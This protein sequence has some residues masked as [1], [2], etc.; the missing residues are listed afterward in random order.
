MDLVVAT[1]NIH[2]AVGR[3]GRRDADRIITVLREVDADVIALQEADERFGER[4][5][6]LPKAWIDDTPW[7]IVPLAKRPRSMGWHGNALLVR[8]DI[9][10]EAAMP[11]D[12]PTLEPRGA[13]LAVLERDGQRFAIVG[14]HLCLSGMRRRA[15]IKAILAQIDALPGGDALA[16]LITGDF[17]Q[18]GVATGAMRAFDQ[19]ASGNWQMIAPDATFPSNRAIARLDRIVASKAWAIS[20]AGAHHSV[21]SSVASDHLPLVAALSL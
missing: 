6:V 4:A 18:W 3:D 19:H 17:N 2:K 16:T 9:T 5:S 14:A 20:T 11:L 21:L 12:L 13:V 7:K 15:Q 10:V 8:R 1:Y